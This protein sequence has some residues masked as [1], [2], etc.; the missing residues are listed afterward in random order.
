MWVVGFAALCDDPNVA[1]R[2]RPPTF[3]AKHTVIA[4][5]AKRAAVI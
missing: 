4:S 3:L 1:S 2:V 5:C